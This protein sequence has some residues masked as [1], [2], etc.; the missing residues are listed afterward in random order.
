MGCCTMELHEVITRILRSS[1]CSPIGSKK[2]IEMVKDFIRNH[3]KEV[4][5]NEPEW[6]KWIIFIKNFVS[7]IMRELEKMDC[8]NAASLVIG[9]LSFEY[10]ELENLINT[11]IKDKCEN[12]RQGYCCRELLTYIKSK[13]R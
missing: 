1:S 6:S 2:V 7:P 3:P 12:N 8:C 13:P 10:Q 11:W 4:L 5:V 9:A